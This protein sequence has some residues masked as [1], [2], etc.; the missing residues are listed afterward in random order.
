MT[1]KEKLFVGIGALLVTNLSVV[2]TLVLSGF[3]KNDQA[4][5]PEP[6]P[7]EAVAE[8]PEEAA[9]IAAI[10]DKYK[11]VPS[12]ELPTVKSRLNRINSI[13]EAMYLC[14]DKVEASSPGP[15]SYSIDYNASYQD[16]DNDLYLVFLTLETPS[17]ADGE[18]KLADVT[19]EVEAATKSITNFKIM[20]K[21]KDLE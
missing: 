10:V 16:K 21:D 4:D 8:N 9:K 14:E 7:T 5:V 3:F 15:K 17:T 13:A 12:D 1:L 19:C 6:E 20:D 11:F 18:R 2:L